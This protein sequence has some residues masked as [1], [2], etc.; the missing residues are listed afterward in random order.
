MDRIIEDGDFLYVVMDYGEE[1]D[2]FAMITD[3]QRVSRASPTVG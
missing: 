2:L 1:G 3:K